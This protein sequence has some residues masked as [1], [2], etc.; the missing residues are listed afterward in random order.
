MTSDRERVNLSQR[1][2]EVLNFIVRYT[3]DHHYAPSI[4]EIQVACDISSTS[5]V[6]YALDGLQRKGYI[7]RDVMVPRSIVVQQ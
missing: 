3:A 2:A 6:V 1:Q 5:V 7:T 4:R